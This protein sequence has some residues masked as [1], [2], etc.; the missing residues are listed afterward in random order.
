MTISDARRPQFRSGSIPLPV[1]HLHVQL[2]PQSFRAYVC[3]RLSRLSFRSSSGKDFARAGLGDMSA[4]IKDGVPRKHISIPH[5]DK[6]RGRETG[7]KVQEE[8]SER[9]FRKAILRWAE[10][11]NTTAKETLQ[12]GK[13]LKPWWESESEQ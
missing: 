9:D 11:E 8:A 13:N 1:R 3:F 2:G 5:V 10:A 6:K 4:L 7:E 12:L